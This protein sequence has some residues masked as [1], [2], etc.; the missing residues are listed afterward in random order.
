MTTNII[1]EAETLLDLLDNHDVIK[2]AYRDAYAIRRSQLVDA[3]AIAKG[4][5]VC[6]SS[7]YMLDDDA[8][9]ADL[10][11]ALERIANSEPRQSSKHRGYF[12]ASD[13]YDLQAIAT[14]AIKKA[15]EG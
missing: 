2:K 13:L 14:R 8:T 4:E 1:T 6:G 11:K 3:I 9:K 10:I 7:G 5:C 15:K 12:I